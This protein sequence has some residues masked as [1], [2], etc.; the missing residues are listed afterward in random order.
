MKSALYLIPCTLGDNK[1]IDKVIPSY[2]KEIIKRLKI[3]F[4]E[5]L[6]TARRFLK[7]VEKTIDIDSLEFFEINEHTSPKEVDEFIIPLMNGE[8]AGIIS[9]AGLPCV[10]DPGQLVVELAHQLN[11]KVVPLVGPSSILLALMASGFNGQNFTFNGY[12]PI[13][14]RQRAEKLKQLENRV[15]KENS[16]QIFMEAPYRNMQMLETI[17]QNLKPKS[18]LCIAVDISLE[19]EEI[20]SLPVGDWKKRKTSFHKRP[21]IFILGA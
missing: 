6:R 16:T 10:A 13:D 11:I 18:M 20:I 19:T 7:S 8:D 15:F 14:K 21:A 3:F 5:D 17:T 9:E 1:S 12:L 4:V 2:N